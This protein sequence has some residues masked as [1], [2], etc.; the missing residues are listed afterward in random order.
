M[1]LSYRNRIDI[2]FAVAIILIC[3]VMSSVYASFAQ[4]NHQKSRVEHTYEVI[5]TLQGVISNLTDIQGSVR[6]YVITGM[7]DYLAPYYV[8]LPRVKDGMA[9]L[10]QLVSD[11]PEQAKRCQMLKDHANERINIADTV[12]R[13]YQTDGQEKAF[14]MI[15][16]GSGK[17]EMDEIRIIIADMIAEEQSLLDVRRTSVD[18]FT[19]LT[20]YAGISGVSI[21]III[22]LTVFVLIHREFKYRTRTESS[23][24]EAMDMMEQ[25]NGETKLVGR[26]GDYL[27]GC[28]EREEVYKVISESMPLLFPTSWGSISVFNEKHD[29]L[30][31]AMTWGKLPE[32]IVLEFDAED[33]W[34]LRQGRGHL[35]LPDNSAPTCEHL[36]EVDSK[37]VSFCL[38]MQAQGETIG[39][40]YFGADVDDAKYIG[41]HEMG[42]MRRITE[43][44][45]LALANLDLQ[46]A[47]KEQSIRDP[48]TKLYN[49]RYLEETFSREISRMQRSGKNLSVLIM[50]IDHFKK[51]NDTYGHDAG[52]AVLTAFARVLSQKSR[53][54]DIACRMGG[55]EF[56]L[57]LTDAPGELA[58]ERAEDIRE[59]ASILSIKHGGRTIGVTVSIGVSIYPTHG[60][61]P[62][63]LIKN[64]DKALYQAKNGGR[65]RVVVFDP[66][67][68]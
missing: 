45:S 21:C 32:G 41:R 5:T 20:L 9:K 37:N 11:N 67:K 17:R 25:H 51:V 12:M 55:E 54:E 39:Q 7:E 56:V 50:D 22:L 4:M 28:R 57:V 68:S 3:S 58:V 1:P 13:T 23:L 36:R 19:K 26:M 10:T 52:D 47:L 46:Q 18:G 6:G 15:R 61:T 60:E 43:Q 16:H 27:R 38:P 49:R 30:V 14:A 66:T 65:N 42:T 33:C 59:A 62:E 29:M 44:I 34:A 2:G 31:P 48:M 24:R 8:A 35:V 64:A 40:I 53:K 63:D